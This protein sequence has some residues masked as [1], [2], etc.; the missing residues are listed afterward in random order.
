LINEN[1]DRWVDLVEVAQETDFQEMTFK[2]CVEMLP[3]YLS[4]NM[5]ILHH[6]KVMAKMKFRNLATGEVESERT[7]V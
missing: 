1:V 4:G 2:R 7:V 5:L 6:K 3:S